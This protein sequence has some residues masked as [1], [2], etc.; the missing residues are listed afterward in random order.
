[1]PPH[2]ITT[3][4]AT[5]LLAALGLAT[6]SLGI[7]YSGPVAAQ[8]CAPNTCCATNPTT[9]TPACGAA[10]GN[11]L[12]V[13]SGNK[14]QLEK[15]MP[16]LPGVLGLELVRYYNSEASLSGH[17]GILGRGWRLSYEA[18]LIV[19]P[20]GNSITVHQGDGTQSRYFKSL[21]QPDAGW[22][23]YNSNQP[24]GA[25][26]RAKRAAPGSTQRTEYVLSAGDR[27]VNRQTFDSQGKLVLI[28]AP[29]GEFVSL[30]RDAAGFLLRVTDPQGR[31]LALSYLPPRQVVAGDKFRGIQHID[32]PVGRFGYEYGSPAPQGSTVDARELLANLVKVSLPTHY[33]PGTPANIAGGNE[34]RGVSKSSVSKI[35]HYEDARR[36]SLL[37]G[38]SVQGKGSDE[39]IMD[40]RMVTWGYD[41]RGRANL[42]VKGSYDPA[43]A[44]V[45]QVSLQFQ[46][47]ASDG[48][49]TT[50]LT[51]SLGQTT[52]YSYAQI[53]GQPQLLEVRG[54][55]C[56]TC[57]A[58]NVRYGY[59][60]R[61]RPIQQLE[62]DD[63]GLAVRGILTEYDGV[64]RPIRISAFVWQSGK[65]GPPRLQVRYEYGADPTNRLPVLVARPSVVA[66][67]ERTVR[68]DYNGTGQPTDIN[69][70]GYE[71]LGKK[72]IQRATRYSYSVINGRSVLAQ[73]D[74]PLPN[75]PLSSPVDSD[76]TRVAWDTAGSF[77]TSIEEPGARRSNVQYSGAGLIAQ[78]QNDA[79]A[80]T[81]FEYA[82]AGHVQRISTSGPGWQQP[83][84]Q[85]FKRDALGQ[86]TET[87]EQVG[88]DAS[89]RAR[90]AQ[91]FDITG[92]LQWRASSLGILE[93]HGYDT[94]S[95]I[96]QN[97][98]YSGSMA[99]TLNY[100]F[101]EQGRV[102]SLR[103]ASGAAYQFSY[104]EGSGRVRITDQFGDLL[105]PQSPTSHRDSRQALPRQLVDDF[106]RIVVSINPDSGR[107]I[108]EYNAADQM[109]ASRDALGHQ[110][111]YEYDLRGRI[112]RQTITDV[113]TKQNSQTGW[114]YQGH[115]LTW[116][117]HP[118][119]NER[120]AYDARGFRISKTTALKTSAGEHR[121]TTQYAY[122]AQG[123]LQATS[124]PDGS[125]I[126]YRRN[127]QGQVV[128]LQ[129]Q[130][131]RTPWLRWA[132]AD[133]IIVKDLQRDMVGIK[134]YTSGNGIA[135]QLQRS[136]AGVLARM[137]YR[138]PRQPSLQSAQLDLPGIGTAHAGAPEVSQPARASAS[139]V[140]STA[141]HLPGATSQPTDPRALIDHRYLWDTRGNLLLRQNNMEQ[142]IRGQT[143]AYDLRSRLIASASETAFNRYAY[144][145]M[146]R[147]VLSQQGIKDQSS[148]QGTVKTRYA[149]HAAYRWVSA[150]D[151]Q[152]Q[153]HASYNANGEP[154]SIGER[155]Y[156]W[157]ALGR[158]VQ[159]KS[160]EKLIATYGYNHRGERIRKIAGQ[161]SAAYLYED[162]QLAA[163]LDGK[164]R[165]KRQ[166]IYLAGTPVAAI[167]T[168]DGV[169]STG[170]D[171]SF[172]TVLT[173]LRIIATGLFATDHTL[174]WLHPNHLGAPEAVTDADAELIWQASYTPF[175]Q[176]HIK[177]DN[178]RLD[179]RLPGQF[180]DQESGLYYNRQRYYDP[181]QGRYLTPDPLGTPNGP[182][183]YAYVNYNPLKY[184]DPDG[185]VLFAFDGT[186]NTDD[187][188]W[189]A[190]HNSSKSNVVRFNDAYVD[191]TKYVTGVGTDHAG[192]DNYGDII[193]ASF[194]GLGGAIPDR[195]GNYSGPTRIERML[196]YFGEE[197]DAIADTDVMQ[198][199]IVGFSRGAAEARDFAN[200]L[201]AKTN[202]GWYS[203]TVGTGKIDPITL[204]P[205]SEKRCQRVN[206][207][208]MGLW[209]TVLST[210]RS[211][212]SYSLGIPA[213]FSYVAQA[214]ALNEYRS[215]P[216]GVNAGVTAFT[217]NF[218][219]WDNTRSHLPED[220]H[221][222]GF[223]LESIGASSY[224]PGRIR[225][226]RG[227]IGAHADIGGG[228]G[229]KENGLATVAL[230][231]MVAQAQIADVAM[232]TGRIEI[233]MNN[234][235]IHD[236]SN[237]LR[238]GNPSTTPQIQA[239]G[240]IWGTNTYNVEDRQVNGG[241]GGGTQRT[242]TF[243]PLGDG[244][245]SMTNAD[246]H[247][248]I[249][250]TPRH[251]AND[252][253]RTTDIAEIRDLQNRT[254]T[255]DMQNYMSW[256]RQHGYS[257]AGVP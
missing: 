162:K 25:S 206:F 141:N 105:P 241:L 235:I 201:A 61:G 204:L 140:T 47:K 152:S 142:G 39:K 51:N 180:A 166:Y 43:K 224:A 143:Y 49:G 53:N 221:Y 245:G 138:N 36:P 84:V 176:V 74:G 99:Q 13:M 118:E 73:I 28:T 30:Q 89:Y 34:D 214:V 18:E 108:R 227:F 146:G 144:D 205:I 197:A 157:D 70:S 191:P 9:G 33:D 156:T 193:S 31:F 198:I 188:G 83:R 184:V 255:V 131:V 76:V 91:G 225:I 233:D 222:G 62:L 95:R 129:R 212:T 126:E 238:V 248:F 104:T 56:A 5:L 124:L 57:G 107:T 14:F 251:I 186:D 103:D 242:Q 127:G 54:A 1:M 46:H 234:P 4:L 113:Q 7:G 42:S 243:G 244:S 96:T 254:G 150:G 246:T 109:T 72:T 218:P 203:D 216:A 230:S 32:T 213:Q 199:D 182:N 55:G 132:M 134:A 68:I 87:G 148:M 92:R 168:P 232:E 136:S 23:L 102:R 202:N 80:V 181:E 210:N 11:P 116:L 58:V 147:R 37:T 237:A 236:Q 178:F 27:S 185:L 253:R 250:Y 41:A 20:G 217:S 17:R 24:G 66:G 173:D 10:A 172:G 174:V 85:V 52:R 179:I 151:A 163:E 79:G 50:V 177:G 137:I 149:G 97:G 170:D 100:E 45:E 65:A 135:A 196:L 26:V 29:T 112:Q 215:A 78:V 161:D 59:D 209:D 2:K 164:G 6:A 67:K 208:F 75:G 120:Y 106:G 249:N 115:H 86:V 81:R 12:N 200:R 247:Q 190:N 159:I 119:Q 187:E 117:E 8:A 192:R 38:I 160:A 101:D 128:A 90:S 219:Y 223:P 155:A 139:T 145:A 252:T 110:A 60:K 231:W 114:H 171:D 158:L 16:A 111:R 3:K 94:E 211:G 165:I 19:Q 257:F 226:E 122:D 228:Y 167:D 77:I 63:K 183:R 15:D 64:D 220:N 229:S 22:T 153:T 48:S 82:P 21:V 69:E 194:T 189:L 133:Q 195:G 239:P 256:L 35:Y 98:R 121:S 123:A 130:R 154:Q 40:Q 169:P 71:P 240:T 44:G 93:Q 175:G 125:R 207:R 88:E